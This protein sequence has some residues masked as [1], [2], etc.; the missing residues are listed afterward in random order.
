VAPFLGVSYQLMPGL[1]LA[2]AGWGPSAVAWRR[3]PDPRKLQPTAWDGNPDND[4]D[5]YAATSTGA[6]QRYNLIDSTIIVAYPSLAVAYRPVKWV[7]I[8][9]TGQLVLTQTSFSQAVYSGIV[10]GE[11]PRNDAIAE[12]DVESRPKVVGILGLQVH[13]IESL[14]LGVSWRPGFT[15]E[16]EGTLRL[17]FSDP[18]AKTAELL[19]GLEQTGDAATFIADFPQVLRF[20]AAYAG[21]GWLAEVGGTWEGWSRVQAFHVKTD[22]V[23]VFL[24]DIQVDVPEIVIPKKWKDTFSLRLGGRFELGE[25]IG[26][27]LPLTLRAGYVYETGAAPA[28]TLAL[29]FITTARNQVTFGLSW[30]AGPVTIHLAAS[31]IFQSAVTVTES[32]VVQTASPPPGL[33]YDGLVVGTGTYEAGLTLLE[34]GIEGHFLAE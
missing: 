2:V 24:G 30:A 21:K 32:E 19:G 3:Y 6:P 5:D 11:D 8:G 31:R 33:S 10:A 17:T 20:G 29:D 22:G 28:S 26:A 25:L 16:S 13:P 4:P 34:L 14:S 15:V 23:K 18:L 9:A 12:L 27:D 1:S 7:S